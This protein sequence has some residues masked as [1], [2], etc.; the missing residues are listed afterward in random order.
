MKTQIQ[1]RDIYGY[2]MHEAGWHW[3]SD[4]KK[5]IIIDCGIH[6]RE[7]MSPGKNPVFTHQS[8]RKASSKFFLAF[9]RLF[10]HEVLRCN[11]GE[12]C[13]EIFQKFLKD[14]NW[15]II[16]IANP[17]GYVETWE[18]DRMWRKNMYISETPG[19]KGVDLNRNSDVAWGTKVSLPV[20]IQISQS[21]LDSD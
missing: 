3:L 21:H 10:I 5:S 17:D 1:G 11:S 16:P 4:N 2:V 6:A 8:I 14:Y 13:G 9:C 20:I 7:W 12:F 15:F 18:T 19:C